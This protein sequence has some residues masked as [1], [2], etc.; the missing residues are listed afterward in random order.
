VRYYKQRRSFRA[1]DIRGY[2][3]HVGYNWAG[4]GEGVGNGCSRSLGVAQHYLVF[5]LL[6]QEVNQAG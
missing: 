6:V 1:G 2:H 4:G 3:Y 5:F